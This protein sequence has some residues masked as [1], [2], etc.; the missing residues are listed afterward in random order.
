[1]FSAN[2]SELGFYSS[3]IAIDDINLEGEAFPTTTIKVSPITTSTA[4]K[5]TISPIATTVISFNNTFN[6]SVSNL[7]Q[8]TP[9]YTSSIVQLNVTS[10]LFNIT[11]TDQDDSISNDKLKYLKIFAVVFSSF[12]LIS[13]I[14]IAF[15]IRK[16]NMRK[17]IRPTNEIMMIDP[18]HREIQ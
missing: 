7:T 14:G 16:R 17:K 4:K 9:Y 13:M 12:V 2:R 18:K 5:T 8:S 15:Y 10:M 3:D 11:T 6:S 1:M